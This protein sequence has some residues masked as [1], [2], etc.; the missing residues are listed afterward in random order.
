MKKPLKKFPLKL[1]YK[2]FFKKKIKNNLMSI[3]KL[4]LKSGRIGL[5]SLKNFKLTFNELESIRR[6]IAFKFKSVKLYFRV[7]FNVPLKS[8]PSETRM[9]KGKGKI[10]KWV[11]AVRKGSIFIEFDSFP[12]N[13]LINKILRMA[14]QRLS[15]P[16]KVVK[17]L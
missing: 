16:I 7:E 13:Y 3:F 8:K 6:T 1:K 11:C 14:Y 12:S 2:Y 10:D 4:N 17:R 5:R 15:V 9:G